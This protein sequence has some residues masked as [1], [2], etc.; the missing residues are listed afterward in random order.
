[1]RDPEEETKNRLKAMDQLSKIQGDYVSKMLIGS[2]E[3]EL[4][5][6]PDDEIDRRLEQLGHPASGSCLTQ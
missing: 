1:M 5:E 4:K 6:L 2:L 3:Q